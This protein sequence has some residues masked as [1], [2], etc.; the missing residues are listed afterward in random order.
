MRAGQVASGINSQSD[1]QSPDQSYLHDSRKSVKQDRRSHRADA[2]KDKDEN[3]EKLAKTHWQ[4][5]FH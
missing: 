1:A 5:P 3:T 4:E 2:E